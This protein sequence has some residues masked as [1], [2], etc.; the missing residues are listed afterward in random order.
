M[1]AAPTSSTSLA[2]RNGNLTNCTLHRDISPDTTS[3][4]EIFLNGSL[5]STIDKNSGSSG[6]SPGAT[7]RG[8][9]VIASPRP[10]VTDTPWTLCLSP[11]DMWHRRLDGEVQDG[12]GEISKLGRLHMKALSFWIADFIFALVPKYRGRG[13][14]A[15]GL[16]F[17]SG[18]GSLLA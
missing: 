12:S 13:R 3:S 8:T 18:Y 17:S 7:D 2:T 11:Y 5:K 15:K 9:E 4:V 1:F 10:I 14:T 6:V 16:V